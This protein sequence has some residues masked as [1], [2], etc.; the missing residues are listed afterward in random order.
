MALP[1]GWLRRVI[2]SRER[3]VQRAAPLAGG[4]AP[5][6]WTMGWSDLR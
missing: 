1:R 4:R 2:V 3:V 6:K 5:A